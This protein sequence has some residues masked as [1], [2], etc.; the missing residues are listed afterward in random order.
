MATAFCH[1]PLWPAPSRFFGRWACGICLWW[2]LMVIYVPSW[3]LDVLGKHGRLGENK[4][5]LNEKWL[6]GRWW[7][8]LQSVASIFFFHQGGST[9]CQCP[10]ADDQSVCGQ[11]QRLPR[12]NYNTKGRVGFASN[13]LLGREKKQKRPTADPKWCF[14]VIK[15]SESMNS[16]MAWRWRK[17]MSKAMDR[18]SHGLRLM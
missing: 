9:S 10:N 1:R 16:V 18:R 11:N 4:P 5:T 12:W 2:T 3:V 17:V 7:S 8:L 6:M 14:E 15:D 13:W